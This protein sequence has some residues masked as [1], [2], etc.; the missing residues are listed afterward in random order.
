MIKTFWNITIALVMYAVMAAALRAE[1]SEI[2]IRPDG[3]DGAGDGSAGNPYVRTTAAS[4]DAL[5]NSSTIPSES[6]IH[7]MAGTFRTAQGLT[8]KQNWRLRGAGI[9]VTVVQ[10]DSSLSPPT[11]GLPVIGYPPSIYRT[12]GDE[13]SDVTVD[14]KLDIISGV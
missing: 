1:A 14:W 11:W 7:L 5:I 12:D 10:M 2:W 4:F 13:V 9:D 3:V 8:L 6:T